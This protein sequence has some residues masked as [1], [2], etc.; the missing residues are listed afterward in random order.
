MKLAQIIPKQKILVVD[1]SDMETQGSNTCAPEINLD[2]SLLSSM[3][4]TKLLDL[5]SE[6][7]DVFATVGTPGAQNHVVK[8]TIKTRG[9]PIRQPLCR[10]PVTLKE[11]VDKEVTKMLENRIIRPSASPWSSPVVMVNK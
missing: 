5:L 7:S 9:L 2:S 8:H 6:Y 4:K 3:E 10:M 1:Q 11:T